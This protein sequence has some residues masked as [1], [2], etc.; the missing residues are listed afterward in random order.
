MANWRDPS[1]KNSKANVKIINIDQYYMN[2]AG[3]L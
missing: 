3:T 1:S 2:D